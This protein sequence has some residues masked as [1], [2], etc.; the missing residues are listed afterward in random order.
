MAKANHANT[1]ITM[2]DAIAPNRQRFNVIKGSKG[3]AK[4]TAALIDRLVANLAA[5]APVFPKAPKA[6]RSPYIT[7]YGKILDPEA[8][9]AW[10][11]AQRKGGAL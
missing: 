10:I 5:K 6:L 7:S 2:L 1:I 11:M 4:G 8:H 9:A 3:T